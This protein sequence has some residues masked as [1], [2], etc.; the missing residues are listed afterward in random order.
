[1][2]A[3]AS[4]SPRSERLLTLTVITASVALFG[5]VVVADGMARLWLGGI[6]L[7]LF[8]D[9]VRDVRRPGEIERRQTEFDDQPAGPWLIGMAVFVV[10]N[11]IA[12]S[13][14]RDR[15][16]DE[17]VVFLLYG[18]SFAISYGIGQLVRSAVS[19]LPRYQGAAVRR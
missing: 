8:L 5:A 1:M 18:L 3:N 16:H 15:M 12:I 7:L 14:I 9:V 11:A 19:R 10:L 17:A 4:R 2:D 13:L 6:A